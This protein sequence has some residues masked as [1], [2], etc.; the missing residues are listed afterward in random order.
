MHLNNQHPLKIALAPQSGIADR[1]EFPQMIYDGVK[2]AGHIAQLLKNRDPDDINADIVLFVGDG[3]LLADY[4][5]HFYKKNRNFTA[6]LWLWDCLPP[7]ELAT[8]TARKLE[9]LGRYNYK[10]APKAISAKTNIK[11]IDKLA[12]SLA[13]YRCFAAM[14][15]DLK[16]NI[17]CKNATAGQL[18]IAATRYLSVKWLW[19]NHLIDQIIASTPARQLFLQKNHINAGYVPLGYHQIWGHKMTIERDIDVLFLGRLRKDRRLKVLGKCFDELNSRNI[20]THLAENNCFGR[21]RTELINRSKIVLDIMRIPWEMPVMRPLM[22]AACGAMVVTDWTGDPEPFAP[23]HLV[24]TPP[25]RL[26]ETIIK[27]LQN[28]RKVNKITAAAHEYV[29]K[30]LTLQQSVSS[31]IET[32]NIKKRH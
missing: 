26:S 31:I 5:R 8:G 24:R 11:P 30:H 29:T 14:K 19:D 7:A 6:I 2:R 1:L 28:P 27:Y 4:S 17:I 13:R 22:S 18:F 25:E 9:K 16:N 32:A 20:K 23:E 12:Y 21:Q 15:K 3:R 10:Y